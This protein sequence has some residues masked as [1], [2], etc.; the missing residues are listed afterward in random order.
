MEK[1]DVVIVGAGPASLSLALSLARFKIHTIILE[2]ELEITRDPRAVYLTNDAIRILWDLGLG[3]RLPEIGHELSIVNF[4]KSSLVNKPFYVLDISHDGFWQTLPNAVLFSQPKLESIMRQKV[5]ASPYC[6]MRCGCTVVNKQQDGE[7]PIVQ[8]EDQSGTLHSVMGSFLIGADGKKGVVRKK[9]LEESAGIK[10]V[11]SSF[12]YE[13]TWIAANF[14]ITLPTP[15]THPEFPLW[16]LGFT[17][18]AVYDLFWP[19]GWHFCSPPGKATASGRFG[20]REERL[21]RHELA[22]PDWSDSM[23]AEA[24]LWKHI[25]PMITRKKD[26]SGKLFPCGEVT[27]PR[28]CIEVL[29]CRPYLFSLQVVNKWFDDR[30]ILI[31]DAAHVFPPFG[32]Q[33]IASGFRDAHQLAWRIHL[34]LRLPHSDK[35]L[36]DQLLKGWARERRQGFK[37]AAEL[38]SM[39]GRLCNQGA[40]I[41]FWIFLFVVRLIEGLAAITGI[42][43][44]FSPSEIKGYKNVQGGFFLKEFGGGIRLAQVYVQSKDQFPMLSDELIRRTDTAMTLVVI[45]RGDHGESL[46]EAQAAIRASGIDQSILSET[47][48]R[49]FSPNEP[50]TSRSHEV[51]TYFAT[52]VERLASYGIAVKRGYNPLNYLRRVGLGTNFIIVRSDFYIFAVAKNTKEMAECL[53]GLQRSIKQRT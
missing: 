37:D 17:P 14:K 23:D 32:G 20:P 31:G 7:N 5:A 34:L 12:A 8:Y 4:H 21:W 1:T 45:E 43:N 40:D 24:L 30:T 13:G 51:E 10:Q 27:Y 22:Q 35:G 38:T 11:N 18:E 49:V 25:T 2:K 47:S 53:M 16:D 6:D 50:S 46:A 39:N 26:D 19:T 15:E 28:D 41:Y 52:P 42:P 44:P 33:G 36:S 3:D 9:F 48:I 29:R